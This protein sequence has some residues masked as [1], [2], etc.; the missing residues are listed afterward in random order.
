MK[1]KIT[2]ILQKHFSNTGIDLAAVAQEILEK[3]DPGK[4]FTID[5]KVDDKDNIIGG[6][7]VA[8]TFTEGGD[9]EG[10]KNF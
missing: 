4:A 2:Q 8:K 10:V 5:G 6:E 1:N 7:E 9:K 3:T